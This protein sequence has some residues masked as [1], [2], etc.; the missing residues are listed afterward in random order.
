V[1]TEDLPK[2]QF[3]EPP[4]ESHESLP[5]DI[6]IGL[7][8]YYDIIKPERIDLNNGLTLL[9]SSVGFVCTGKVDLTRSAMHQEGICL[10]T[11]SLPASE[12][13][14][15]MDLS[16][17]WA[18]E[19][20]DLNE[21]PDD[22]IAYK[23]FNESVEF[24]NN[25][26]TVRW[27]WRP[28][29][30]ELPTNYGLAA[31]RLNSLLNRLSSQSNLREQYNAVLQDQLAKG[32]IEEVAHDSG[33]NIHY[34][35]HHCVLK[36]SHLTTKLR[37]VY[38]ASAKASSSSLSLNDCLLAGPNLVPDLRGILLRFRL[39]EIAILSDVEKAFLQLRL[40]PDDRDVTRFLWVCDPDKPA[41][42]DNIVTYRFCRIPF[43]V[44]SSP[45]LLAATIRRHLTLAACPEA[46]S[47]LENIYVDNVF[48]GATNPEEAL[49]RYQYSKLL[50]SQASM[51]LRE[52]SSNSTTFT[53]HL[54]EAD[55]A[56]GEVQKCLGL[57]W[58]TLEDDISIAPINASRTSVRTKRHILQVMSKFYDPLGAFSPV[59]IRAKIL[60][61]E[62]WNLKVSWDDELPPPI[63]QRWKSIAADLDLATTVSLPRRVTGDRQVCELH[64]FC[65]ASELAYGVV[66]YVRS[67]QM[68]QSHVNLLFSKT[69]VA[70]LRTQ[71]IP[72][73]ELMA[74]TLGSQVITFLRHQLPLAFTAHLWTDSTTVLHWLNS[75]DRLPAFVKHRVNSITE[76][77][78]VAHHHISSSQNPADIPSRGS[79][80]SA[81]VSNSLWWNG[82][83]ALRLPG[84]TAPVIAAVAVGESSPENPE[85]ER[86]ERER[87]LSDDLLTNKKKSDAHPV[88][89]KNGD[90]T[91][92]PPFGIDVSRFSSFYTLVRVSA[93]CVCF[94]SRLR[95]RTSPGG[96]AKEPLPTIA[97]D[98]EHA[99]SLWIRHIQ[100][101]EYSDVL[102][103]LR[104]KKPHEMITRLGL[105]LDDEG[106]IRCRGRLGNADLQY[107]TK[108]PV[109][110]PRKHNI[111]KLIINDCHRKVFH[112]GVAHTLSSV[113]QTYWI[114]KGR[115]VV[116]SVLSKCQLCKKHEGGSYAI[117]PMAPLPSSRVTP[118]R[119]FARTGIDYFGPV[120]VKHHP[121]AKKTWVCLFTCML[122][123]AIHLELVHDMTAA[124]FL[125]SFRRFVARRCTPDLVVSDNAAQFKAVD[126][127][128]ATA[129]NQMLRM[130]DVLSHFTTNN[131]QWQ[132]IV[133]SAPWMGG[134]YER[135]VGVV[136]RGMRKA[137]G[138]SLLTH[139][140]L[141][142]VLV[143]V[144]AIVNSRP[145]VYV[146][147]DIEDI[148]LTPAHFLTIGTSTGGIHLPED[149]AADD[150][151]FQPKETTT[152]A[153]LKL[154]KSGQ[155][156]LQ[157]FWSR[158]REDYLLNLRE[159]H[160]S[161]HKQHRTSVAT[162]PSVNDVVLIK[163]DLPR[164]RWR[165]GRIIGLTPS[166]DGHVRSATVRTPDKRQLIRPISHLYPLE[167]CNKTTSDTVPSDSLVPVAAMPTSSPPGDSPV[168][169]TTTS[170]RPRRTAAS[171]QRD[172][173]QE[174]IA[175]NQL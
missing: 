69:R 25:R 48:M 88:E 108:F 16:R 53:S 168:P 19:D 71:S 98:L 102:T 148:I 62:I 128:I 152:Q 137:I 131:I 100:Q 157:Q 70:P 96:V 115:A 161:V 126:N 94:V 77:P 84:P 76:V 1:P 18:L 26:Y 155:R 32:I 149:D 33:G 46:S 57:L 91:A 134:F 164:G 103:Q 112:F 4:S 72:R 74:M 43:G 133:Q 59:L 41:S 28:M 2:V 122:T 35:P 51:N 11:T 81:L 60:V 54:P 14:P 111:A 20:L 141:N 95:Q 55:R 89:K 29:D 17:F 3:A 6:L 119:A 12:T 118:G 44:V 106:I 146:G 144:E 121:E 158:W 23:H 120:Y 68:D 37:L 49:E 162:S 38:D 99:R 151:D 156:R 82:P 116:K 174:L 15:G 87:G 52:W 40:H 36:P 142:T 150:P 175:N 117:P 132:F 73:L 42:R 13:D 166:A 58:N 139:S 153:L 66:A 8:Y 78:N 79:T 160:T 170:T 147:D 123:R 169:V 22:D 83:D 167:L 140:Q 39:P 64:V 143:E 34:L 9:N 130:D 154:W 171:H 45:F 163:D 24:E 31:G 125:L 90:E 145:L 105:F 5:I 113:R 114:P 127:T 104:T 80:T 173:L 92:L 124:E 107:S 110:V 136:K 172:Q 135:L 7:D 97:P 129:F 109:L 65:D 67:I 85:L 93:L 165:L 27:P 75:T 61:Q 101:L 56:T 63:L 159:A 30:D 138:R 10:L 86:V 21:T 50:F 47:L